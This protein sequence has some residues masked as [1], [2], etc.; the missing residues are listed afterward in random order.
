MIPLTASPSTS[1]AVPSSS[2]SSGFSHSSSSSSPSSSLLLPCVIPLS[3]HGDQLKASILKRFEANNSD[4]AA[5]WTEMSRIPCSC[6]SHDIINRLMSDS[7]N[8]TNGSHKRKALLRIRTHLQ[9]IMKTVFKLL[10][11]PST[12]NELWMSFCKHIGMST[13][14]ANGCCFLAQLFDDGCSSLTES[15]WLQL[16]EFWN[17]LVRQHYPMDIIQELVREQLVTLRKQSKQEKLS[18]PN[19]QL[20]D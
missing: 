5:Y 16:S 2:S 12:D 19:M 1:F 17:E 10:S 9:H 14:D 20:M 4:F 15:I 18:H 7:D 6:N 11:L 3:S 8:S 13:E